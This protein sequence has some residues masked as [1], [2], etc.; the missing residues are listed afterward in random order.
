MCALGWVGW[1][2]TLVD[3]LQQLASEAFGMEL[4][5]S[6]CSVV[7]QREVEP[8]AA[9]QTIGLRRL[10]ASAERLARCSYSMPNMPPIWEALH[11][12]P[13]ALPF[14]P[15]QGQGRHPGLHRGICRQL[16]RGRHGGHGALLPGQVSPIITCTSFSKLHRFTRTQHNWPYYTT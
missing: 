7:G 8:G 1:L 12:V 11:F 5:R 6:P 2:A 10:G 3:V 4:Q 15:L 13:K 14:C 9:G 16:W